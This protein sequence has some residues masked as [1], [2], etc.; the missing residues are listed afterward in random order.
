MQPNQNE[1]QT[2]ELSDSRGIHTDNL[3]IADY[4][5]LRIHLWP[6]FVQATLHTMKL[7][8]ILG[9]DLESDAIEM[10]SLETAKNYWHDSV[11]LKFSCFT[12]IREFLW[13][14]NKSHFNQ[15][16][17][18]QLNGSCDSFN[19]WIISFVLYC[20]RIVIQFWCM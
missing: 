16:N 10:H 14:K 12:W 4:V 17:N 7:L 20:Y 5:L 1:L 9:F 2:N 18:K 6:F 19:G 11:S 15:L 3:I 13:T 8:K